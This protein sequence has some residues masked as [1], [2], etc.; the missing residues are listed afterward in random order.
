MTLAQA[1]QKVEQK[2]PSQ[3]AKYAKVFD[4]PKEEN[5]PLNDPSTMQ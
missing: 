4:E 5:S 2:L 1:A 3:H